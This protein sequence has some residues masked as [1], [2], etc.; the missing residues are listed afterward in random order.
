MFCLKIE[1]R[2]KK[3]SIVSSFYANRYVFDPMNKAAHSTEALP[4]TQ[5]IY[6]HSLIIRRQREAEREAE[7]AT[8]EAP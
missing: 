6:V 5:H 1:G 3:T 7:R 2:D 8:G 4:S